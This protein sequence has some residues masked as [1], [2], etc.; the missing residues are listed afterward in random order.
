[1]MHDDISAEVKKVDEDPACSLNLFLLAATV[2]RMCTGALH[3]HHGSA[4]A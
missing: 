1:M 4:L 2:H 3:H